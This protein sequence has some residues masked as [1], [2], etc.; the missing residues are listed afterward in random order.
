MFTCF[1]YISMHNVNFTHDK[2]SNKHISIMC[3]HYIV[4][5]RIRRIWC[6][7]EACVIFPSVS[8]RYRSSPGETQ[9]NVFLYW[10]RWIHPPTHLCLSSPLCLLCVEGGKKSHH[11]FSVHHLGLFTLISFCSCF[12]CNIRSSFFLSL[13]IFLSFSLLMCMANNV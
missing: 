11:C 9:V 10:T 7:Q 1:S 5:S 2:R 8:Q 13:P 3:H 6:T 12:I 4:I